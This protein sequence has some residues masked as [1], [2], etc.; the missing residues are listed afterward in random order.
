MGMQ[1][2]H[3]VRKTQKVVILLHLKQQVENY[4]ILTNLSFLQWQYALCVIFFLSCKT[5]MATGDLS[6]L[7]YTT[8][9]PAFLATL[10]NFMHNTNKLTFG[11][12]VFK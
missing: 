7:A 12:Y 6:V 8:Y 5:Q 10:N 3:T 2:Y 9:E 11:R 1:E 4:I